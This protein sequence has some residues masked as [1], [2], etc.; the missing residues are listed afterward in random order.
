[1]QRKA[2]PKRKSDIS[3]LRETQELILQQQELK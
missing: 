1:M 3:F 2:Q